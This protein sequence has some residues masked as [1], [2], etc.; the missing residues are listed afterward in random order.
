MKLTLIT[1][2][3]TQTRRRSDASLGLLLDPLHRVAEVGPPG[4]IAATL[5]GMSAYFLSH[6]PEFV[7]AM[8][9][10]SA[11]V[12]WIAGFILAR[13]RGDYDRRIAH[14]GLISKGVGIL[15]CVLLLVFERGVAGSGLDTKG[16]LAA[17][18]ATALFVQDLRSLEEKSGKKIPL[19]SAGLDVL[20]AIAR[21]RL[22]GGGKGA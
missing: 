22:P 14:H 4:W 10:T 17:A 3:Q 2:K 20:D 11:I 8:A 9:A 6:V 18:I 7:L 19:L 1:S 21:K 15:V 16:Y 12:D 5:A 13:I